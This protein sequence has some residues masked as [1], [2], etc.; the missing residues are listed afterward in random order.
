[1]K[2]FT[3]EGH[4]L[5]CFDFDETYFPHAC[6]SAQLTSVRQLEDFL[7]RH[8]TQLSTM[9]VTG[10]SLESIQEK[11]KQANLRFWPHR[12]AS[13]LGTELYRI[14]ADGTFS[15]EQAYQNSFP[16]DF[17]SRVERIV[18]KIVQMRIELEE[19]PGNGTS[20][21][22][23]SYYVRDQIGSWRESLRMLADE[24]EIAVNISQCNP[25]AGDPADAF[26]IDFYPIYAGKESSIEYVCTTSSFV[27]EDAY[28]FGDSGN[29]LGMLAHVGNGYLLKN[30]TA[31]AKQAYSK[32]T[33]KTYADGILEVLESNVSS[34]I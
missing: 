20:P 3:N 2:R 25:N 5:V 4:I 32:V 7:E 21:W 9:W 30:A 24:E 10:S 15:I 22:I 23:R 12:I 29:D 28:A 13:S 14:D 18:S 11:T 31:Q 8:S 17:A 1:M 27:R 16:N 6:S 26:D 34:F 33:K 19:Q